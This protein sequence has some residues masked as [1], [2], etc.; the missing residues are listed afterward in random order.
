MSCSE[1]KC[2]KCASTE[3]TGVRAESHAVYSDTGR[4]SSESSAQSNNKIFAWRAENP[5]K[6]MKSVSVWNTTLLH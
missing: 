3:Q 5:T 1:N 4:A 6:H 2:S